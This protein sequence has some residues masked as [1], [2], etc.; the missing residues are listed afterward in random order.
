MYIHMNLYAFVIKDQN[1]H[2]FII[3]YGT[4]FDGYGSAISFVL[5]DRNFLLFFAFYFVHISVIVRFN[6]IRPII[7]TCQ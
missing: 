5:G 2:L 3:W 4:M 6:Y 7:T 1:N